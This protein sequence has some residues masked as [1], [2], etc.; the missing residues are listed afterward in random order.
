VGTV[1]AQP[2]HPGRTWLDA[3]KDAGYIDREATRA[4]EARQDR[5]SALTEPDRPAGAPVSPERTAERRSAAAAQVM[6]ELGIEAPEPSELPAAPQDRPVVA[7]GPP[8]DPERARKDARN[9]ADRRRRLIE[10]DAAVA[11][12]ARPRGFR[13]K[14]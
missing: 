2:D 7:V 9:L 10:W 3:W 8:V 13:P 1:P 4:D 14:I 11:R 12:G 5:L 6:A